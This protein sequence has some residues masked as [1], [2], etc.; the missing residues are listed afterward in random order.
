M[1][2]TEIFQNDL[3]NL[4]ISYD[5]CIAEIV[6]QNTILSECVCEDGLLA[7][8][9]YPLVAIDKAEHELAQIKKDYHEFMAIMGEYKSIDEIGETLFEMDKEIMNEKYGT[10][11]K[12]DD[13]F[14]ERMS[15]IS[16]DL[17]NRFNRAQ[18]IIGRY[19][20]FEYY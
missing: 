5:E 13:L 14:V 19:S 20:I 9:E 10:N 18:D 15:L 16:N 1:I 7:E 4:Y 17:M 11:E 6:V 12:K 8:A 3:A 2:N